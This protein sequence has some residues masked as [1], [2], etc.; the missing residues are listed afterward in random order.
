MNGLDRAALQSNPRWA[1]DR[2]ALGR[3]AYNNLR[4]EVFQVD[5]DEL[6]EIDTVTRIQ[7]VNVETA[8]LNDFSLG[9]TALRVPKST[10]GYYT[11]T[12]QFSRQGLRVLDARVRWQPSP[13]GQS[14]PFVAV[15]G[16]QQTNS[17]FDMKA[18]GYYGEAGYVFSA[19]TWTPT[20]SYRFASFSGDDPATGRFER[21]DPLL[22]GGNGETWVQG[23]NHFKIFQNS[24]LITH[25]VQA[26][27]RPSPSVELVPQLWWFR[28]DSTTN[29]GG[30]PALSFLP[31]K[32][33]GFE[34]NLTAKYFLSRTVLFQGHLAATFAGNAV[35]QSLGSS[36]SPWL[37]AM[38]FVRVG[39]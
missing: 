17:H 20:F 5:P 32:N 24:N 10:A 2:V 1:G 28:A 39:F 14:G 37:S 13:V 29:L 12:S 6:P 19:A 25:R 33:L 34:A 9:V 8:A 26:R 35:K 7:G 30:N 31:S 3:L 27:L 22:S 21:W 15:E 11:T 23:I 16:A 36:S 38:A 4:F 18:W